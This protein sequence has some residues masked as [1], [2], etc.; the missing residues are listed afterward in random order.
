M[1]LRSAVPAYL[2]SMPT[3]ALLWFRRDLRVARPS[4]ADARARASTTASCRSSCSTTRCC[5]GRFASAPRTAFMLGCLRALDA[6]LRERGSGLVV[7]HGPARGRARRA[8]ARGRRASAVLLD[9]RRRAVRARAATARVTSALREAG[10][11]ARPQGG[12]YVVDVSKPRT[13]GGKPYTVFIAVSPPLAGRSSG[14]RSTARPPSCRRCRARC[15]RAGCR[16]RRRSALGAARVAPSRSASPASR[17]RA[18]RSRAGST[19][20]I[21]GYADAHDRARASTARAGC[22]RTCAGAASRRAE[23]EQR[24]ARRGGA[25]AAALDPPARA[26][27]TST[28]TSCSRTPTTR[29]GSSRRA[30]ATSS[31][32]TT[33]SALEAWR[34]GPDRLSA[35]RRRDAPARRGPAGCTTARG[36][37]SA[38]S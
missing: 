22:R 34:D 27:A 31:G 24:A 19:A 21:D 10:V 16:A 15:A 30:T 23:C 25:G 4:R 12:T 2:I 18:R 14:A 32:T 35:R 17:R 8:R 5:T 7:R 1:S 3:T 38:R 20:P 37:S 33:P 11:A 36:W 26:G 9:E 13:Q 29:A 28:P 6:A